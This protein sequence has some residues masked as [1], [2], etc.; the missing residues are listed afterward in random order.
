MGL[1]VSHQKRGFTLVEIVVALGIVAIL[2][3]VVIG[4]VQEGRKKARDSQRLSDL[5]QLQVA[6]RLYKDANGVY[7][8]TCP[9]N[10]GVWRSPGIGSATWYTQCSDYISGLVPDYIAALPT[11]PVYENINNSGFM[12]RSDATGY[13]VLLFPTEKEIRQQGTE[14]ARCSSS[15][16]AVTYSYCAS[17]VNVMAIYSDSSPGDGAGPECW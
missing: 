2:A 15:C 8:S 9:L 4:S 3:T 14:Y 12:Y 11:D 5:Q 13:K 10:P 6:L 1:F 17:H 16:S 7:P